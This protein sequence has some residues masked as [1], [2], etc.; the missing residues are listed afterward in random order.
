MSRGG[1]GNGFL[2]SARTGRKMTSIRRGFKDH[3]LRSL[4]PLHQQLD[5]RQE[6]PRWRKWR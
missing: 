3:K 4:K 2:G 5:A 1:R 6:P